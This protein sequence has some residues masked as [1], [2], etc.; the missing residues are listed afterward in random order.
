LPEHIKATIKTLVSVAVKEND[1][2]A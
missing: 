2:V 1:G